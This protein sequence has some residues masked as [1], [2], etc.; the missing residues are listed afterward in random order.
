M[1]SGATPVNY[2]D[3][4]G[5]TDQQHCFAV[6]EVLPVSIVTATFGRS[7]KAATFGA[8]DAVQTTSFSSF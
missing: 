8:E 5:T 2:L 3:R 4:G 7:F 6:A 1:Y